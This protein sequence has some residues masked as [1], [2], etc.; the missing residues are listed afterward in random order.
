MEDRLTQTF[1]A[2]FESAVDHLPYSVVAF[3]VLFLFVLIGSAVS[4]AVIYIGRNTRM[5][6]TLAT[7]CHFP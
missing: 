1:N 3:V 7:C 4:K 2:M 6:Q 5:D